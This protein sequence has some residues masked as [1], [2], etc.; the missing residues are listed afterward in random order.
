MRLKLQQLQRV[1]KTAVQ[2]ERLT[3]AFRNE[4]KR[5]L[6][7]IINT[8]VK[9]ESLAFE[10]NERL[11]TLTRTGRENT[12][13]GFKPSVVARLAYHKSPEVRRMAA[14]LLPERFLSKFKNDRSM[15]VK[16]VLA[17]RLP[18]KEVAQLVRKKRGND[19]LFTIYKSRK[20]NEDGIPQPKVDDEDFDMYG[21]ERLGDSVK[22]QEGPELSDAWYHDKAQLFLDDHGSSVD[23]HWEET[24]VKNYCD[25]VKATSGVKVDYEKMFDAINDQVTDVEDRVLER[26]SLKET[27]EFLLT[28]MEKEVLNEGIMPELGDESDP[29]SSLIESNLSSSAFLEK[30]NELFDVREYALPSALKKYTIGEGFPTSIVTLPA[31]A[32]VPHKLGIRRIDEIALDKYV[33]CWNSKQ[34]LTGEPVKIK[35]DVSPVVLGE[36]TFEALLR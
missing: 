6:G 15:L 7:P 1:V 34:S 30:M 32:R 19:E 25:H 16:A 33:D 5:V 24:A 12:I 9:L 14:K 3:E 4:V 22:Q 10:V 31:K 28:S 26:D 20:L 35:W 29:V 17:K 21:E 27:I 36:I 2:E 23:S 18:L 13:A 8:D 11:E